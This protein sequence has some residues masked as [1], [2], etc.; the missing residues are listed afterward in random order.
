[1][2]DTQRLNIALNSNEQYLPS[3]SELLDSDDIPVDNV[4]VS[5]SRSEDQNWIPNVLLMLLKN[6]WGESRSERLRQRTDWF[7]GVDM[8]VYHATGKNARVP[9]VPDGFLSLG[10]E[11]RKNNKSRRGYVVWEKQNIDPVLALEVV[12][13]TPG[14]EY[15]DKQAIYAKLGVLYYVI[16]NPEFWR[17]DGHQPLEVYKLVGGIYQLQIGEPLWMPEIGLGI[18]RCPEIFA[19]SN[20]EVLS[21]FDERGD[22]YLRAEE[23]EIQARA[24]ADRA[25]QKA[26]KLLAKLQELG[27]DGDSLE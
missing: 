23:K 10:V 13:W 18:G 8:G 1:M 14:G 7:F 9:I 17:R 20:E 21:W 19:G 3:G 6:I 12:S 26:E 4:G 5:P 27:I 11:R 25:K 2:L 16:Y 15:D 24:E 22:Q